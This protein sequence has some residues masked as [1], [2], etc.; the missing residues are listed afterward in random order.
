M[1]KQPLIIGVAGGSGSGKTTVVRNLLQLVG[2]E[3]A[4]II[5]HDYYY[6]NQDHIP[7]ADR[8]KT[9][10][11]HPDSLETALLITHLKQLLA[12]NPI[13]L[14]QYD[15]VQH[16]RSQ[17]TLRT[18]P[19]PLILLDG[20]LIFSDQEL[21]KLCDFKIFVDTDPDVRLAR[22]LTRDVAE[23]GRTFTFGLEQYLTFT[24]PMHQQFVEPTK[25]FAD[26]IIPE[27]G[28]NSAALEI[29]SSFVRQKL[30]SSV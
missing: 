13:N 28:E 15:F 11:D 18:T 7:L 26:V 30:T 21:R 6:K 12:G 27:G 8:P 14:P 16:T 3:N 29:V 20:I 10:Y 19:K 4:V 2:E 23:R 17:T 1:P 9:N 5:N 22:R 25:R 24:R